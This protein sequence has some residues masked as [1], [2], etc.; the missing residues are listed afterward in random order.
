MHQLPGD[1]ET[2]SGEQGSTSM[3][4]H[5]KRIFNDCEVRIENSASRGL[6]SDAEQLPRVTKFSIRTEQPLWILFLAYSSFDNRI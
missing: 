3:N 2:D 5:H 6:P 4:L 1:E